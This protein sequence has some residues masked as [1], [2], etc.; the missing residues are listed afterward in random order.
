MISRALLGVDETAVS[1]G[2]KVYVI[3]PPTIRVL[4][5][6]GM[7]LTTRIKGSFDLS[8]VLGELKDS[9]NLA[10]ALSW[11]IKGDESLTEELSKGTFVEVV[12]A[13][14]KAYSLISIENFCRL[15]VLKK[16]VSRMIAK[17]KS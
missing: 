1:V 5:G 2:G 3:K 7:Y 4:A 6:A 8:E 9:T 16:S 17:Q 14:E 12:N 13:L 10:K 15:S 11:F